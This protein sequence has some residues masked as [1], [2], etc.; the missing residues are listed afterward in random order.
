L[1]HSFFYHLGHDRSQ[2]RR[3]LAREAAFQAFAMAPEAPEVHLALGFYHYW[4][5][6]DYVVALQEFER[7]E[8]GLPSNAEVLEAKALVFRRQGRWEEALDHFR[9]A[10]RLNPRDASLVGELAETQVNTRKFRQGILN[11][12]RAIELAPAETWLY[13]GKTWAFWMWKGTVEEARATLDQMPP[14]EDSQAEGILFWQDVFETD[15]RAA[16]ELLTEFPGQWIT[17]TESRSPTALLAAHAH[18]Y[19]GEDDLAQ[20]AFESARVML[21][22]EVSDWPEDPRPRSALGIALAGLGL[23]EEAVRQGQRAV[24]LHP[25]SRDAFSGAYYLSELAFIYTLVGEHDLAIDLLE[26]LLSVPSLL[27]APMLRLDP[28]WNPLENNARYQELLKN[29]SAGEPI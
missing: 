3:N 2:T 8:A 12:E 19:L 14:T 1:A 9:L 18:S 23:E 13:L 25:M 26:E 16:L 5:E 10:L 24:D 6:G 28:R 21:E 7:A 29:H 4:V 11:F 15:Y 22:A 27:S 17:S 20:T